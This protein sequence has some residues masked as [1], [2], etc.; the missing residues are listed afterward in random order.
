MK[1]CLLVIDMQKEFKDGCLS[2]RMADKDFVE[3]VRQLIEFC[4]EKGIEVVF[5]QHFI[6]KDFS[7]KEKY[8]DNPCYCIE[9]TKGAEFIE[10]IVPSGNEKIFRKHR[11]SGLYKTG[12]GEYLRKKRCEEI[13][14]CGVMTNCCIRQTALELQI[15]DFKVLIIDDCCATTDRKIHEFTLEDIENLV[16]GVKVLKLKEFEKIN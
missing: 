6:K 16:S 5:T 13:I 10:G 7:N 15:R 2:C 12:L 8:E 9:G 3:R 14:I 11:I 4:R 1:K